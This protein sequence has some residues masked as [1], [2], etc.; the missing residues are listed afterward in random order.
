MARAHTMTRDVS[1]LTDRTFDVL[2]VGGGIYGLTIAYDCAQRGLAV[3]LIER[4]DFGS[5]A[6]F[7]H[8]RT[9]HGGLRYLQTLDIARAR[10][11]VC[12]RRTF[13]RIAPDALHLQPFVLPLLGS[14][15]SLMRGTAAMRAGFAL[16]RLI[17]F[18]RNRDVPAGLRVPAGEVLSRAEAISRFPELD[19]KDNDLTGAAVWYDYVSTE[20]DRLTFSFG[21]AAA[22]HSAELANYVEAV[23]PLVE[24]T[25]VTGVR[26][27]DGLSGRTIEIGARVTVNAA[28]AGV[29]RWLGAVSAVGPADDISRIPLLKAMNLVTRREAGCAAVG[30]RAASGRNLFLVPWKNRAL[31]GTWESDRLSDGDAARVTEAEVMTFIG[32]INQAFPSLALTFADVTLV[33]RGLVPASKSGAGQVELERHERV[34]DRPDGLITV[35]GTKYTTARAVAQRITDLVCKKL[36]RTPVPCHTATTPLPYKTDVDLLEAVRDEMVVTLADAIVRRTP[37]GALGFPGD[38]AV[39][40]AAGIVGA[41]LEWS[42]ERTQQ[43]IH[44]VRHFYA[45]V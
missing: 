14:L 23:A 28:G 34:D 39:T 45:P 8:L 31:F 5:G 10:E 22:A 43:E 27:V 15:T 3:A 6:S 4:S 26:A 1:R 32:E 41:A 12:E 21:L 25:R 42:A 9:I 16:D 30:G 37:L 38:A 17:A 11:S 2:V 24:S 13:A 20:S 18:D 33:H 40:R 35:A 36:G 29:N 19:A 44:D 7:N